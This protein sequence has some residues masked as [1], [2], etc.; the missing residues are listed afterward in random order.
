L[1][2]A[3]FLFPLNPFP[4][5]YD[6]LATVPCRPPHPPTLAFFFL[7]GFVWEGWRLPPVLFSLGILPLLLLQQNWLDMQVKFLFCKQGAGSAP[8]SHRRLPRSSR[9]TPPR[10]LGS[11]ILAQGFLRELLV[12][13]NYARS[14]FIFFS[15]FKP[16]L[17]LRI[18][19][20]A[21]Q[22]PPALQLWFF[23]LP[24]PKWRLVQRGFDLLRVLHP[25]FSSSSTICAPGVNTFFH[26][27]PPPLLC[28]FQVRH[29]ENRFSRM[30]AGAWAR[31]VHFLPQSFPPECLFAG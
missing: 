26:S 19:W 3:H 27:L 24:P 17:F 11:P 15:L 5:L 10:T 1:F 16:L 30:G 7:C 31:L 21:V 6:A 20:G 13:L 14:P 25:C 28:S 18:P 29:G 2:C 12:G 22:V 8:L 4:G 9:E 23:F